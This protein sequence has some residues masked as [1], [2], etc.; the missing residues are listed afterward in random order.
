MNMVEDCFKN[1]I[2]VFDFP[3]SKLRKI[4]SDFYISFVSVD[5]KYDKDF[6][7]MKESSVKRD[8]NGVSLVPLT[9]LDDY[10]LAIQKSDDNF[11]SKTY[12]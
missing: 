9:R 7:R 11:L 10:L 2:N 1:K 4:D 12:L 5:G 3:F 8:S 6:L